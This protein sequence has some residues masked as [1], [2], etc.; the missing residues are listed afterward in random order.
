MIVT[1]TH[2]SYFL[3]CHRKLWLF[4]HEIRMEQTSDLVSEGRLIQETT[5]P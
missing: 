4:A 2:I 1:G 5:Y 3:I